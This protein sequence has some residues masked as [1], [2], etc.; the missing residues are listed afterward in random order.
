MSV[1]FTN[2]APTCAT[3]SWSATPAQA[4]PPS[5]SACWPRRTA[6]RLRTAIPPI[7]DIP[8][9]KIPKVGSAH[10][11]SPRCPRSTGD[12]GSTCSTH[13]GSPISSGTCAP[14]CALLMRPCSWSA[15]STESTAS[16]GCSGTNAPPPQRPARS[17]SPNSTVP[18]PTSPRPSASARRCSGR[19]CSRF[20]CRSAARGLPNPCRVSSDTGWSTCWRLPRTV[21]RARTAMRARTAGLGRL[22]RPATP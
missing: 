3:S 6:V 7:P 1:P 16:R 5:P 20:T 8:I 2:A 9:M 22:P 11:T 10:S 15:P 13:R 21:R 4:R 14:A 18:R 17:R 19:A 12:C